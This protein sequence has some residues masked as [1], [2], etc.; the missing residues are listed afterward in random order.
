VS[1]LLLERHAE[2][3]VTV[4]GHA[5]IDIVQRIEARIRFVHN[6][7]D[8]GCLAHL[9]APILQLAIYDSI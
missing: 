2:T 8:L 7:I 5:D 6:A 1:A 9:L 3:D 4:C